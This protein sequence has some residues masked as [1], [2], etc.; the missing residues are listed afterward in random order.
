MSRSLV[1]AFKNQTLA[2]SL[3]P[4]VFALL[5]FQGGAVRVWNG[6]GTRSWASNNYTGVGHLGSISTIEETAD[7]RANSVTL[8]LSG[9]P[10][11]LIS[12]VLGD[13]YSGRDVKIW[14]GALDAAGAIVADP[15]LRF[16]GRMSNVEIDEGPDTAVIKVLA[17]SKLA[18][19]QRSRERRYTHEDQQIDF[20]GDLGLQLMPTAQSRPLYWG[21]RQAFPVAG[22]SPGFA[23]TLV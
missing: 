17:E 23:T 8:A 5:D 18:D 2:A 10:S 4:V 12:T 22:R 20:A 13:N 3:S 1:T 6:L 19:L 21:G 15:N 11:S 14:I 7:I 9:V 16:S